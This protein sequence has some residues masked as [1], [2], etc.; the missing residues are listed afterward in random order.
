MIKKII[1]ILIVIMCMHMSVFADEIYIDDEPFYNETAESIVTGQLKIEPANVINYIIDS[2]FGEIKESGS[3]M[4]TLILL[5]ALSGV[6]G[7]MQGSLKDSKIAEGAF[8]AMFTIIS[9]VAVK[10]FSI[11]V[12]YAMDVITA[13]TDFITKISPIFTVLIMSSG[14]P[15]S[16]AAF[17]PILSTAVYVITT[18]MDKCI[19]PLVQFGAVLA[20][21]NN[22][23]GKTQISGFNNLVNSITKWILTAVL[24]I[25]ASITAIYGFSAPVLDNVGAKAVKFAVGSIVPVVG[26]LLADTVETVLGGTQLMKNAVGTAGMITMC[27]M[28]AVPVIKIF[29]IFIMLKLS[30]AIIEPMTDRRISNLLQD[31]ASSVLTLL[32]M[33]ITIAMLFMICISIILSVTTLMH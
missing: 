26:G 28:C 23:S 14:A 17:H 12:T 19:I 8:F 3:L 11:A 31:I 5:G 6:L 2:L 22:I 13:M 16:A 18:I 20:I 15:V 27:V 1:Y 4:A 33:I 7:V 24:T 21:V 29:A 10:S 30:A 32:T 9:C 25:F